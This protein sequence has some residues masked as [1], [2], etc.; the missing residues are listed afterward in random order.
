MARRGAASYAAAGA[1]RQEMLAAF[2]PRLTVELGA[3]PG[4]VHRSVD[5]SMLSADI[6]GFTTLSERQSGKGKSGA[7]D[8][9]RIISSCFT[10]L[11]DAAYAHDGE[12]IKFGGDALLILFRG[13]SHQRRAAGAG[14][15]MQRALASSPTARRTKLTMTVGVSD[16]PFDAFLVGTLRRE[17]LIIG[18][19]ADRVIELE[20]AARPGE[21]LVSPSVA[22]HFDTTDRLG[23]HDEGIVLAPD[24]NVAP[25]GVTER[26][27][28]GV[29]VDVYVPGPVVEQ[30]EGFARLGGEHRFATVGFLQVSGV[31]EMIAEDPQR[32]AAEMGAIVDRAEAACRRFGAAGLETDIGGDGFKFV[33]SAGA[34]LARGNTND[35]LLQ[36]ALD[37]VA[38]PTS[39]GVRVGAQTGRVFAGFIGHQFRWTYT[40][41][42]DCMSTAARMLG[43]ADD[44][45]VVAV[46]DVLDDTRLGYVTE[47]FDPFMVKGKTAPITA[48]RVLGID[49][50]VPDERTAAVELI[51]R[52]DEVDALSTIIGSPGGTAI[53]TGAP[54]SGT[55]SV[56]DAAIAAALDE[57]PHRHVVRA[58]G[59]P[60]R[61]DEPYHVARRI[62]AEALGSVGQVSTAVDLADVVATVAPSLGALTPLVADVLGLT[63]ESTPEVEDIGE[64]FRRSRTIGTTIELLGS[65][66]DTAGLVVAVDDAHWLDESSMALLVELRRAASDHGWTVVSTH[67]GADRDDAADDDPTGVGLTL[68]IGPLDADAVRSIAIARADRPLSDSDLDLIVGRADGNPLYVVELVRAIADHGAAGLPDSIEKLVSTRVDALEPIGRRLVRVAAVVGSEVDEDR[69][70]EVVARREGDDVAARVG[71]VLRTELRGFLAEQSPGVWAFD[72][73]LYRDVAYEGLPFEERRRLHAEVADLIERDADVDVLPHAAEL[74]WHW[75]HTGEAIKSWKLAVM[76][77]DRA[78]ELSAPNDAA[79]LYERA[80]AGARRRGAATARQRSEIAGRL[81]DAALTA[82]R[83]DA[84]DEAFRFARR[85]LG[86]DDHQQLPLF[87]KTGLV[88]ERRG[89]YAG[90]VRW[91]D[92]GREAY[93]GANHSDTDELHELE[94]ATAGIRFRQG[95]YDECRAVAEMVADDVTASPVLRLR[96]CSLLQLSGQYLGDRELRTRSSERGRRLIEIVDDPVVEANFLNNLGIAAYYDG[97]WDRAAELYGRSLDRREAAGDLIGSVTSLNNL[98]ELRSDQGRLG[99]ARELFDDALRRSRAAGYEMAVQV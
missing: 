97:E 11:I 75:S 69:L 87:R 89:D 58:T 99:D 94:V 86:S 25:I 41:M 26:D 42:G 35:A 80:L 44:R 47:P 82:G 79:T 21:T 64:D 53:V 23:G 31:R 93:E 12:V 63:M 29:E 39:L 49:E 7:E 52:A 30:L 54:G 13:A 36:V 18:E 66:P 9:A 92:R 90:A 56:L 48:A 96:A 68:G 27:F 20:S 14:L 60:H 73:A 6:S 72:Q 1:E 5:G 51:G 55:T 50:S 83:F 77:A 85:Q 8:L 59:S 98:G 34:P 78:I 22:E 67:T 3:T 38:M 17:V 74:S 28:D 61:T 33:L 46:A 43:R 70:V 84:A 95:R 91:Y 88:N 16:G 15:A 62:V 32:A 19:A 57:H 45:G 4:N 40:M 10:D 24:T 65:I 71:H 2:V 81:G 37:V 76:A